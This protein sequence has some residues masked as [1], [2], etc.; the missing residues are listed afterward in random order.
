MT[1]YVIAI[2]GLR[3]LCKQIWL[4]VENLYLVFIFSTQISHLYIS[5]M[6]VSVKMAKLITI[7][8]SVKTLVNSHIT[9]IKYV[10]V[11]V[12]LTLVGCCQSLL[13]FVCLKSDY[14]SIN[15]KTIVKGCNQTN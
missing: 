2:Y 6:L 4:S 15:I 12:K 7:T 8:H 13:T 9:I 14:C 1:Q 3:M 11:V 10:C 5:S